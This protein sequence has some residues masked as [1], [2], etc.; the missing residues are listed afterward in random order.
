MLTINNTLI[1]FMRMDKNS[2]LRV[3][4]SQNEKRLLYSFGY[5]MHL[6]RCKASIKNAT[7]GIRL[8]VYCSKMFVTAEWKVHLQFMQSSELSYKPW[9]INCTLLA[10]SF[11]AATILYQYQWHKF[12]KFAKPCQTL[13]VFT[14]Q[15]LW[16]CDSNYLLLPA[17]LV[18]LKMVHAYTVFCAQG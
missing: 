17:A 15:H 18:F 4:Y 1:S 10:N 3:L 8:L 13:L 6:G 9:C 7:L 2:H 16:N 11:F 14:Q 5:S 12:L